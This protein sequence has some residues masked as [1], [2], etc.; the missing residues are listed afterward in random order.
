[1]VHFIACSKTNNA[2]RISD[3]FFKEVVRLH[4]LLKIIVSDRDV[5][6][7]SHFWRILW[8]KL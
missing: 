4:G 6:F 8:N 5:K 7:L 2:T 1:M 3:L